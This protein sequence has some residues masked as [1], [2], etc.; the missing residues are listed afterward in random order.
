[1][2]DKSPF[3]GS[4]FSSD[5]FSPEERAQI[6]EMKH[7]VELTWA[8]T[9]WL[10]DMLNGGRSLVAIITALALIGAA[11]AYLNNIGIFG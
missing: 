2:A 8:G 3:S 5:E 4:G 9:K 10:S 1:M 6:R 7:N 11:I